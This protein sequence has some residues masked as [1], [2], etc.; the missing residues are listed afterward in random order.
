MY[1]SCGKELPVRKDMALVL[2][3]EAQAG[4]VKGETGIEG[5]RLDFNAGLR[6]DVPEGS[7]RIRVEDGISGQ[8]FFEGEIS[9]DRLQSFEQY[10]VPWQ[11]SV[12]RDGELVEVL[13]VAIQVECPQVVIS[14]TLNVLVTDRVLFRDEYLLLPGGTREDSLKVACGEGWFLLGDNTLASRDSRYWGPVKLTS[15]NAWKVRKMRV[16]ASE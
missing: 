4:P 3:N 13:T 8:V 15:Q 11:I 16:T 12:W 1:F 6:L 2:A 5:L 7:W 14:Q 10:Y 9:G